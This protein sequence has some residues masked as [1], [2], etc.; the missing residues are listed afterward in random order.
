MNRNLIFNDCGTAIIQL[1]N[2]G[3]TYIGVQINNCG[4]GIDI[5]A[6]S[7][8]KQQVG[9]LTLI[10]SA[11]ANTP[12]GIVTAWSPSS[13]PATAGSV[14]LENVA[15]Q[16]VPVAVSGPSGTMLSGSSGSTTITAW[17]QGHRYTPNGPTN[18]VGAIA[19]NSRP[20]A[21]LDGNKYYTRSKPQYESLPASSFVSV[22]SAGARGDAAADDVSS[23]PTLRHGRASTD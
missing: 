18:Q 12:V 10:D 1:W 7:D 17:S 22:R 21:L 5:S 4:K 20:S 3:W 8:G 11:I 6:N 16:N 23:L 15:L 19:A 14:V 13:Q 9:S 2:W